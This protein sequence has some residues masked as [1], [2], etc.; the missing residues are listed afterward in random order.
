VYSARHALARR[1]ASVPDPHRFLVAF[2][3]HLAVELGSVTRCPRLKR[4]LEGEIERR[5]A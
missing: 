2:L 4:M 1:I 3:R 5:R